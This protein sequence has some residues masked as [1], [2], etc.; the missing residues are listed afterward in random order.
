MPLAIDKD[1]AIRLRMGLRRSLVASRGLRMDHC[2]G[3]KAPPESQPKGSHKHPHLNARVSAGSRRAADDATN[4]DDELG[5]A[6]HAGDKA[7]T[8]DK[9]GDHRHHTVDVFASEVI[10]IA[11]AIAKAT[12]KAMAMATATAKAMVA[13]I[14]IDVASS[15]STIVVEAPA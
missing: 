8:V 3:L 7:A 9:L 4:V 1:V 2:H 15:A 5:E 12:A 6:S 11:I 14:S 10:V 13:T